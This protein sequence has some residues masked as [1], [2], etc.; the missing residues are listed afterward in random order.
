MVSSQAPPSSEF[1]SRLWKRS[2][3]PSQTRHRMPFAAA[4]WQRARLSA[5]APV[6]SS[7][8]SM[9][10]KPVAATSAMRDAVVDSAGGLTQPNDA[11]AG[12]APLEAAR[13]RAG[14]CDAATARGAASPASAIVSASANALMVLCMALTRR[15]PALASIL[16][17][18][19]RFR[20]CSNACEAVLLGGPKNL[21]DPRIH[22]TLALIAFFA[23]VGLG[24]D[25]LSSSCYGPRGGVP[26]ARRAPAPRALPDRRDDAHRV[27][28]LGLLQPDHRAV[29]ERRRRLPGRHQAAR[30][31]PRRRLGR[32][33]GGRLRAHHRDLGGLGRATRS[34][35]S[36][37][38]TGTRSEAAVRV[39]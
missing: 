29:P 35:R 4:R 18:V 7:A 22:H 9:R 34:S 23:W 32:R 24:S 10:S 20:R 15:S 30:A 38:R 5:T 14:S 13:T 1:G 37:R 27:P 16:C 11:N 25:G 6:S 12:S 8:G 39:R 3:R 28:D 17:R 19:P 26:R 36:C 33:A 2:K 31:H 21:F